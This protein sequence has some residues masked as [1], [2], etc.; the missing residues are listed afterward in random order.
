MEDGSRLSIARPVLPT[1]YFLVE[2][3]GLQLAC[4]DASSSTSIVADPANR[5]DNGTGSTSFPG[6]RDARQFE[7]QTDRV[8]TFTTA[9]LTDPVEWTGAVH[10]VISARVGAPDCD[11]IVRLLS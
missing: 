7:S 8:K 2:G 5:A 11:I 4:P 10:A 9:V 3:G 6:A 1:Q